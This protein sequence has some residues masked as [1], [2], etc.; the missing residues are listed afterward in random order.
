MPVLSSMT[1]L[2]NLRGSVNVPHVYYGLVLWTLGETP[3]TNVAEWF[4]L[5]GM[6]QGSALGPQQQQQTHHRDHPTTNGE[7]RA[8]DILDA[9]SHKLKLDKSNILL[10]GPTG[11]GKYS[12]CMAPTAGVEQS[13]CVLVG[14]F[15]AKR[16]FTVQ[17][18][19]KTLLAQTLA[20]CL[21]VP[22]A[23]CDCTT[24]TQA[25]YVGED[26]ESVIAKLLQDANNNVDKAQQGSICARITF[27][28]FVTTKQFQ[29]NSTRAIQVQTTI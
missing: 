16:G 12:E 2:S 28:V 23:I 17:F 14:A 5:T 4:T 29:N 13:F 27:T 19:G 7:K 21:D 10:L 3:D 25:G 20:R 6:G 8:S 11:S 24:L 22:F 9:T 18:T 15:E 26:I 1:V